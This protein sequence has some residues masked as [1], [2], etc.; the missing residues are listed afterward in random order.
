MWFS[1]TYGDLA[2]FVLIPFLV[3]A[4][5]F[6]LSSKHILEKINRSLNH[7]LVPFGPVI[8]TIVGLLFVQNNFQ[9][10]LVLAIASGVI[11]YITVRDVIPVGKK[12][13]PIYFLA[14]ILIAASTFVIF[15]SA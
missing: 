4:F 7:L 2:Y 8:G 15:S 9:V 11:P 13:K 3:R 12:G 10:F 1:L 5:S 14:G 6:S